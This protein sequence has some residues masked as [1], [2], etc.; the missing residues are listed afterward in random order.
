M[1][2]KPK[3]PRKPRRPHRTPPGISPGQ[4]RA[5]SLVLCSGARD[6]G[7]AETFLM[8]AGLLRDPLVSNN[9]LGATDCRPKI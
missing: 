3:G 4:A 7:E 9:H 1:V 8:V 6:R 2:T 5:A